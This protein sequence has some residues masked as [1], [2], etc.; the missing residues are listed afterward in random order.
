MLRQ[1]INKKINSV[2]DLLLAVL[3]WCLLEAASFAF[4]YFFDFYYLLPFPADEPSASLVYQRTMRPLLMKKDIRLTSWIETDRDLLWKVRPFLHLRAENINLRGVPGSDYKYFTIRT[5]SQGFRSPEFTVERNGTA[6][7]RIIGIGDSNMFGWAVDEER[8]F[9]GILREK[10]KALNCELINMGEPGYTS[11]QGLI[12]F[13]KYAL[14]LRPE[15]LMVWYGGNDKYEKRGLTDSKIIAFNHT[16]LGTTHSFL[17]RH[18]FV[19]RVLTKIFWPVTEDRGGSKR[20]TCRVPPREFKRN[21]SEIAVLSK[22]NH[23]K[24]IYLCR[25]LPE[26][27]YFKITKEVAKTYRQQ[28]VP[29]RELFRKHSVAHTFLIWKIAPSWKEFE[30][31]FINDWII[32]VDGHQ[33]FRGNDILAESLFEMFKKDI[34]R[35]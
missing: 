9:C 31:G 32:P 11:T 24:V 3:F 14:P 33:T 15:F 19:F 17:F 5:N 6:S 28:F 22:E 25:F 10:L 1:L 16:F 13:K 12:L 29:V 27:P 34:R 20:W 26:D 30:S 23:I 8:G 7:S 4:L 18:S 21:L 2:Y 35:N